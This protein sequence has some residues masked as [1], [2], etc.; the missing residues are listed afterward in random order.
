MTHSRTV[1]Q[2]WVKQPLPIKWNIYDI[3]GF[4][5]Q[6][7][8]QLQLCSERWSSLNFLTH[9]R[10]LEMQTFLILSWRCVVYIRRIYYKTF[11]SS[12]TQKKKKSFSHCNIRFGLSEL[13]FKLSKPP[14]SSGLFFMRQTVHDLSVGYNICSKRFPHFFELSQKPGRM[15]ELLF[16]CQ[17]QRKPL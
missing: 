1:C 8:S 4:P 15:C 14:F 17:K 10:G 16:W 9:Q 12:W 2:P 3:L 7:C 6:S 13:S 11:L 5:S